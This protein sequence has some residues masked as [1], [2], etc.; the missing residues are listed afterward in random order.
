MELERLKIL[1]KPLNQKGASWKDHTE[2][3][4]NPSQVSIQK[5]ASYSQTPRRQSNTPNVSLTHGNG[6]TLSM[7][8]F[9]DTYEEGK[10][11]RDLTKKIYDLVKVDGGEH[12]TLLCKLVWGKELF[13]GVLQS[14]SQ[15]FTLFLP[16]GLPVR[17]T[18]SCTF[19]ESR[20]KEEDAK[21][22]NHLS[23]DVAKTRIVKRGDSLSG[24]AAVEYGDPALWRP[25]AEENEIDDP[26]RL[27]PGRRLS[28]PALKGR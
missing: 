22:T 17:A 7:E 13:Q 27:V 28:I 6:A 12:K 15:R 25:I 10:D 20:S 21:D 14:V 2:V 9:F 23:A 4:F 11:V 19:R 24:I 16:S 5:S 3:S 1:T 18:L 26:S 8:L